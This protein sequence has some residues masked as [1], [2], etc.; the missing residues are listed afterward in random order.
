[1][2]RYLSDKKLSVDV[3]TMNLGLDN[4]VSGSF[5]LEKRTVFV[6]ISWMTGPGL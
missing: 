3:S 4:D 5:F 2:G 6:G 1:M